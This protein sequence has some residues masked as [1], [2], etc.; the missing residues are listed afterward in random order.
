MER[1]ANS[2]EWRS[3]RFGLLLHQFETALQQAYRFTM[4]TAPQ[5]LLGGQP[6]V[7]DGAR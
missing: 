4:G 7:A 6:E 1:N 5:G 2:S 3:G